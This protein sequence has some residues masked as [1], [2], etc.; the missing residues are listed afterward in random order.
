M[1]FYFQV[2]TDFENIDTTKFM[3]NIVDADNINHIVVFLTGAQPFP[4]GLGGSGS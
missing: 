1:Y 3:I 2:Q 4:E